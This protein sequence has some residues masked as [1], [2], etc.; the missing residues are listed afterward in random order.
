MTYCNVK[1]NNMLTKT[2][3]HTINQLTTIINKITITIVIQITNFR[4]IDYITFMATMKI[5]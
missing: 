5:F 4:I 3:I 1:T 2:L